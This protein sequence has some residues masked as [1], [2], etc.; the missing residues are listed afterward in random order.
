MAEVPHHKCASVVNLPC[1]GGHVE[2]LAGAIVDMRQNDDRD[3]S[4]EQG[5]D[6]RAIDA[7]QSPFH[8]AAR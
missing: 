7:N 2:Q 3:V 1:D 6:R 4:I 8:R 5:L